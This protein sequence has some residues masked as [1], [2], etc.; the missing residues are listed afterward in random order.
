MAYPERIDEIYRIACIR[1]YK[2]SEDNLGDLIDHR[3]K[4][5]SNKIAEYLK[6]QI[7]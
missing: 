6:A 7:K 5:I 1:L 3:R 2:R 4:L